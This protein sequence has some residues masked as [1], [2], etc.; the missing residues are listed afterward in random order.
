MKFEENQSM[1]RRSFYAGFIS[2]ATKQRR[3]FNSI[4]NL[5]K[6]G[7]T[8]CFY[9]VYQDF[10]FVP[11]YGNSVFTDGKYENNVVIVKD[12][13]LL[14]ICGLYEDDM[15]STKGSRLKIAGANGVRVWDCTTGKLL[16]NY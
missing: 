12:N 3:N 9:N 7:D 8:I 2:H 10:D 15:W 6:T 4:D 11:I 5:P 14:A 13:K 1:A 16:E